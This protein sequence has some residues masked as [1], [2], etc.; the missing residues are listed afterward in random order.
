MGASTVGE[1]RFSCLVSPFYVNA[2]SQYALVFAVCILLIRYRFD[3]VVYILITG[4]V[5]HPDGIRSD[6]S[7]CWTSKPWLPVRYEFGPNSLERSGSSKSLCS[8]LERLLA[9]E[10]NLY[11]GV[12]VVVAVYHFG[13]LCSVFWFLL[14]RSLMSNNVGQRSSQNQTPEEG[15]HASKYEI[16]G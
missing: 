8:T 6:L 1:V 13:F 9:W 7:S 4:A 10:N 2:T 16:P 11:Q 5:H 12:K 3:V 15:V 14:Y